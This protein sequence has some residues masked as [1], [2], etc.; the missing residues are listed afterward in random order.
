MTQDFCRNIQRFI[1]LVLALAVGAGTTGAGVLV[2][3]GEG[4]VF[5][6][7]DG[8]RYESSSGV[9][10]TGVDRLLGFNVN[11][12][13]WADS[14]GTVFTGVDG[15]TFTG[16]DGA[17][18]T[19]TNSL[20]AVQADGVTF[21]GADGVTFT[22]A[23][24]VTFTGADGTTYRANAVTIR[25]ANGVVFTG[26]DG[27]V[28]T[29]VDGLQQS[30]EDGVTFTGADGGTM[31]Q[32]DSAR[33]DSARQLVATGT[34]GRIFTV[35]PAGVVFTGIDGIVF[36]GVDGTTFTG[37][38]GITFTGADDLLMTE[39]SVG[40]ERVG[41]Q[42]IDPELAALLNETTD[43]R[44]INAVIV[45]HRP[46]TEADIAHLQG[47]GVTG[48]TRYRVLP[49]L[50][51]TATR[52]Q[53]E[54]ISKL[55]G[56]RSIWGNRTLQWTADE[57]R[58]QTR[59]NL[60]LTDAEL[61]LRNNGA[62]L[63]GR[64]V[65]VAVLDT[66]LDAT[67]ADLS[68]RV[69]R[70][71]KLADPQDTIPAGFSYPNQIEG[72]SNTD[73]ASGHGTFVGGIIAG[74]GARSGGKFKGV[75]PGARL[76]G[77]SAG[78]VNLF[79]VLSGF[80]YLLS[81][82]AALGVRVVNC[83]FSASTLYNPN[84]PVNVAT[85]MLTERGVNI[86]FSAG[87]TGLSS[88]NPYAAAPWV[89]S[90]G[91]TSGKNLLADFSS[92]GT[93]GSPTARPTLVAPGVDVVSLR[94]SLLNATGV[95]GLTPLGA[96]TRQLT[97]SEANHYTTASGTSF[98]APQV[99]G[100]IALMLEANPSLTPAEVRD[101]L[102]STAT[103]LPPYYAHEVGA[104]LLNTHAAVLAAEFPERRIGM[105]RSTADQGQVR[106]VK[107]AAVEFSGMVTPGA[108]D[109]VSFTIPEGTLTASVQVA[110]GPHATVNDL[111][112]AVFD[113]GGARRAF[114]NLVNLPG[115]TGRREHAQLK[116]PVAGAWRARV[117]NTL[118]LV[119]TPQNYS[120]VFEVSRVEYPA[121]S[122]FDAMS[123]ASRDEARQVLR[124]FVMFPVGGYF[125]PAD[126]VTRADLAATLVRGARVP[127]YAPAQPSYTDVLDQTTMNYVESAQCS[128]SAPLFYD[129][130]T[131]G[132]FRPD[133][134]A[135]RLASAVAL[136]RAAGLQSEAENYTG[137]ETL[138]LDLSAVPAEL[139]G[140]VKL[141]VARGLLPAHGSY[142]HPQTAL[143]RAE[144]AHAMIAFGKLVTK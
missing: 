4:V 3:E 93:F 33:L 41:L 62:P 81:N 56:V 83:S 88:L 92:R 58:A 98:S 74:D 87:N 85:K 72:L 89:I 103:P 121:L 64:G 30:A 86:V 137:T 31:K 51:I 67:H 49:M 135:T 117:A 124:S 53:I 7:V 101:I 23:D 21:T 114:S 78:D 48:G 129:A 91:A 68:G 70:N 143:T 2:R 26:V 136:V 134:Q 59:A 122:D 32:A 131:G 111:S 45:Y 94:A 82:R 95:T 141:A 54:V 17:S 19:G 76:V 126:M 66:G 18:Y 6:G 104:G 107:D 55:A 34:N 16:V 29:G 36:T 44:N 113:A 65:T 20:Q 50:T 118:P 43:D 115:L 42:T 47:L 63:S 138:L 73:Q 133:E 71:V 57:S 12:I 142:F 110:W 11:G 120:G 100:A 106:F 105:W 108:P 24:G 38:D 8:I 97:L 75:A 119:G 9:V 130:A 102:Q 52:Y 10:F 46:V 25:D 99:V 35:E 84:D 37:A 128:V 1:A 112:L 116:S 144:L 22:G 60:A 39:A 15:T 77:L 127:Q 139:R 132:A 90:V 140:Y 14:A 96:D 109:D 125:R 79:Y 27:V 40:G 69:L 28:F 61:A 5:T 80:D 13:S 123:A